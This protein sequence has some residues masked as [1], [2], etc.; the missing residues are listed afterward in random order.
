MPDDYTNRAAGHSK[1]VGGLQFHKHRS[2]NW[3][4]NLDHSRRHEELPLFRRY[5]KTPEDYPPYDNYDAI[6]VSYVKD[7]PEDYDGV[8]GVPITFLD[9]HNPE[10]FE[11]VDANDISKA[12][13][14][15]P[16]DQR[17]L[18]GWRQEVQAHRH[19][20]EA[21]K[22]DQRS[23]SVRDLVDG[24]SDDGADGVVG[25]GRRLDIRPPF[26]R[27]FVVPVVSVVE[28]EAV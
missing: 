18:R 10:Q 22:V 16:L 13:G 27:E 2:I 26:Q 1:W 8:M 7:I 24:Y 25:Y 28:D 12:R 19:Q 15:V 5:A 3:F 6:E 4:T 11:I 14:G 9:K 20:E 17:R 21:M 23:V